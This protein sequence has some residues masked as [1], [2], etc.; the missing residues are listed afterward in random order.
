MDYIIKLKKIANNIMATYHNYSKATDFP[1]GL[2]ENRLKN[3]IDKGGISQILRSIRTS[4]DTITL[5]FAGTLTGSDTTA[6]ATIISS[7]QTDEAKCN[8][9]ES[10]IPAKA[11]T[12]S[13]VYEVIAS[14][15]YGGKKSAYTISHV[16]ILAYQDSGVTSY[17]I[18]IFDKMNH[19]VMYEATYTNTSEKIHVIQ[20]PDNQSF[21]ETLIEVQFRVVGGDE[22]NVVHVESI[23]VC[24]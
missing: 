19:A 20:N 8:S 12:Y 2:D 24:A 13:P 9:F 16:T 17:N 10:I 23:K 14:Y 6:L 7:H 18:R 15:L 1:G 11:T 5:K 4:G 22:D 3:D 21:D